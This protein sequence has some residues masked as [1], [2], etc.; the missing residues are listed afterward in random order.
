[1]HTHTYIYI[2]IYMYIYIYIHTYI[3]VCVIYVCIYIYIHIYKYTCLYVCMYVC[4]YVCIYIY[5]YVSLSLYIYIYIY[6]SIYI[7]IYLSISLSI[8][9]YIPRPASPPLDARR[10]H[11]RLRV[12]HRSS[13]SLELGA[14]FCNLCV[15]VC[16]FE[17]YVQHGSMVN[18][19]WMAQE[20]RALDIRGAIPLAPSGI[21]SP[22][23]RPRS[24]PR[25][26]RD[27]GE[28]RRT[29]ERSRA[30]PAR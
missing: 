28:N 19:V 18:I 2:Y 26:R 5:I 11:T 20:A 17:M 29:T 6:L 23:P 10:K 4:M 15:C 13:S 27:R 25:A 14:T 3:H 21:R 8:Y 22:G 9:I 1:M 16:V 24:P 12:T 7:S 30:F